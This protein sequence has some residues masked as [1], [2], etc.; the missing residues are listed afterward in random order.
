MTVNLDWPWRLIDSPVRCMQARLGAAPQLAWALL[1]V[2]L[3]ALLVGGTGAVTS[4]RF[5]AAANSLHGVVAPPPTTYVLLPLSVVYGFLGFAA[6]VGAVVALG[7][8]TTQSGLRGRLVELSGLAYWSQ[9]LWSAPALL[10]MWLYLDPEPF[11][12][13]SNMDVMTPAMAYREI[14]GP[15]PLQIVM[16]RTQQFAGIW[17]VG[18]HATVLRVVAGFTIGGTWAAG[19][20]M[21]SVFL[22]I[23]AVLQAVVQRLLF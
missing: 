7:A 4:A 13:P 16:A 8:M 11:V 14:V 18:L 3:N 17:L 15:E 9:V 20:A 2:A 5:A 21:G 10:V 1:P 6:H 23:P 22:G 12:L 19:F